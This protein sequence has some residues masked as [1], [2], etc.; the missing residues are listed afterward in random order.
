[1]SFFKC[2]KNKKPPVPENGMLIQF[3]VRYSKEETSLSSGPC[4]VWEEFEDVPVAASK[5]SLKICDYDDLQAA[6]SYVN[7]L[8]NKIKHV[9]NYALVTKGGI[10]VT[11]SFGNITFNGDKTI[12]DLADTLKVL[13]DQYALPQP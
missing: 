12:Q 11:G 10:K 7:Q 6:I 13:N 8:L 5:D 3:N 9:P 1:M 2:H 4:C